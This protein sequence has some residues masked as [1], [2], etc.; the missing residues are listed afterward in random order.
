M[1]SGTHALV[2]GAA[3]FIGSH[4]VERL[5]RDG[6]MVRAFVHYNA[7]NYR[8]NLERLAPEIRGALEVVAGDIADPFSVN[9]AVAGQDVVFHLASLIAI[10][11]S[12]LAPAAYV[13]TNVT[14]TLNVLQAC[15]EHGV[16]RLVHTSTS[17]TYGTAQYVPIDEQHPL[18]GQ[19]P[20]SASKIAADKLAE[21]FHRSYELPVVTVRPFNTFG[22]RQSARAVVPTIICQA[23]TLDEIRIGSL[24]PVRDFT[25]VED[26][27]AGFVA[28][29]KC[30]QAVGEVVNLGTGAGVSI[31]DIVGKVRER[32]N[33]DVRVRTDEGR[34][35]PEASEVLRLI[36]DNSKAKRLMGWTPTVNFDTGL[37][38]VLDDIRTH[39]EQYKAEIYNV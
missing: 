17:E 3:G 11:Y 13:S 39:P 24:N 15:R 18:V 19:S 21:S 29:A 4:L 22:P 35:R 34:V 2:T 32:I 26:T 7:A 20:Y 28:A 16:T 31:G 25:Y 37:E 9:H 10:P 30:D 23:L 38:R 36:S 5:V 14:G 27:A 1:S 8:H 33:R 12:Y 6:W